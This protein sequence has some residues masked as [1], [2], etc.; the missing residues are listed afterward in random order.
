MVRAMVVASYSSYIGNI[1]HDAESFIYLLITSV[2][3]SQEDCTLLQLLARSLLQAIKVF[4]CLIVAGKMSV[5]VCQFC[6]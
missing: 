6:N 1:L 2:K 5:Y 3:T 4:H